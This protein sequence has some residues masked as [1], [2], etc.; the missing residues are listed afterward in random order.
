MGRGWPCAKGEEKV[1]KGGERGERGG[2]IGV[3]AVWAYEG[4]EGKVGLAH[5]VDGREAWFAF[6]S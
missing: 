3:D 6:P 2:L 4:M 1:G 5:D